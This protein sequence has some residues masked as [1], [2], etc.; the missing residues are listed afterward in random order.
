[1]GC[2]EGGGIASSR[3]SSVCV[4]RRV[5]CLSSNGN[6][7]LLY[8][9]RYTFLQPFF[10]KPEGSHSKPEHEAQS[11]TEAIRF[12]RVHLLSASQCVETSESQNLDQFH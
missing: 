11:A 9:A 6:C 2:A 3:W 7:T 1:M 10:G 4:V 5:P 8:F 12:M